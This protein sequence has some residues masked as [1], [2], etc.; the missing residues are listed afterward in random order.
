MSE[1]GELDEKAASLSPAGPGALK[2]VRELATLRM[3]LG[4]SYS[5]MLPFVHFS[6]I[7]KAMVEGER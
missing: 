7:L 5:T 3:P 4:C 6:L 1:M 2:E